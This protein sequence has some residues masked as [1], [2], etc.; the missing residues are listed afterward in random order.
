MS[1]SWKS[2]WMNMWSH[3]GAWGGRHGLIPLCVFLKLKSVY[4]MYK[5][6][7]KFDVCRPSLMDV[8]FAWSQGATFAEVL[9]KTSIFEGTIVRCASGVGGFC[10]HVRGRGGRHLLSGQR[11]VFTPYNSTQVLLHL[12]A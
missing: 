4:C 7:L 10:V 2:M 9:E 6:I 3:S 12:L 5:L 11:K 1:A 8:I